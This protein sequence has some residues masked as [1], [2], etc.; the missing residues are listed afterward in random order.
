MIER[1]SIIELTREE[2]VAQLDDEAR[3]RRGVS[4]AALL[5]A[6]RDGTLENPGDVADLIAFARLLP[7]DDPFFA[8]L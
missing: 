1:D 2:I 6:Y 8:A 3:R 5:R 7:E 4:G